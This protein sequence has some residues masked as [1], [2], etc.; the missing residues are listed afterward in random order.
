M[1]SRR[2]GATLRSTSRS[3]I[4]LSPLK[5][6]F[7]HP[8][9]GLVNTGSGGPERA[10]ACTISTSASA[11]R[12]T[13]ASQPSVWTRWKYGRPLEHGGVVVA[14]LLDR[15]VEPQHSASAAGAPDR[16][17]HARPGPHQ[18]EAVTSTPTS[19][20][21]SGRTSSA[22]PTRAASVDRDDRGTTYGRAPA[23]DERERSGAPR[24]ATATGVAASGAGSRAGARARGTRRRRAPRADG[25]PHVALRR[26]LQRD[27]ECLL[28]AWGR[29]AS[30]WRSR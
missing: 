20:P 8:P 23:A 26:P 11:A 19:S 13:T 1:T 16:E 24:A 30:R 6:R 22:A 27:V 5:T 10:G 17:Q 12:R 25:D 2:A 3:E 21:T 4:R 9:R 28:P 15:D 7:S 18:R 14:V 29:C